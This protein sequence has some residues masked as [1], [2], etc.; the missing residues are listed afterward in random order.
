MLLEPKFGIDF[1]KFIQA[2]SLFCNIFQ[3]RGDLPG[4]PF[5]EVGKLIKTRGINSANVGLA[6]TAATIHLLDLGKQVDISP[7]NAAAMSAALSS[8]SIQKLGTDIVRAAEERMRALTS[9]R[10]TWSNEEF[11]NKLAELGTQMEQAQQKPKERDAD[12]EPFPAIPDPEV[13][14][15][16]ED[17]TVGDAA[18]IRITATRH[19]ARALASKPSGTREPE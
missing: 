5:F 18:R 4:D 9:R 15:P 14:R 2:R 17:A 16:A 8:E 13:L 19:R 3:S 6:I 1:G 11:A 10:D 12:I 7:D